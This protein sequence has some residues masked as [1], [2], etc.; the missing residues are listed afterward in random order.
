MQ[1]ELLPPNT[2][3]EQMEC[4]LAQLTIAL[5]QK[6]KQLNLNKGI[7]QGHLRIAQLSKKTQ[8]P[9]Y[10]HYTNPKDKK[11]R[12]IS[13]K[14]TKL[15]VQLAQKDY[16]ISIIKLLKKQIEATRQYLKNINSI[17]ACYT[18]L[19]PARQQLITPVTLTDKQY[20][21]QWQ[22]VSWQG[23]SFADD[24]PAHTTS[25]G[26]RVRSKS[27]VLI[28]DTLYRLKIPYRYEFPL[29]IKRYPKEKHS[30]SITFHPDFMCLNVRTRKE[31]YWEHFGLM[32]NFEYAQNTAGKLRLYAENNIFPGQNLI[33]TMET[34]AE[35]LTTK[36]VEM[37]IKAFLL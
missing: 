2:I 16:D 3:K 20:A 31:F 26:E 15:A 17:S 36:I 7:P 34:Q 37:M 21:E 30:Q 25:K 8:K 12:F 11:G 6:Q 33:I 27:E 18:N 22:S 13:R 28:A 1:K 10:Y 29:E 5:N 9:Q 32:D 14:E 23:R 35:P 24:S 19:S 4:W